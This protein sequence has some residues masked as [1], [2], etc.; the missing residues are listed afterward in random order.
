MCEGGELYDRVLEEKRF[1]ENDAAVIFE[2]ILKAINYLH[3]KGI[4]HRDIKPENFLLISSDPKCLDLK[5]I[6]FGLSKILNKSVVLKE[7]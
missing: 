3:N 4:A 6:D 1:N 2:Q 5:M 7:E